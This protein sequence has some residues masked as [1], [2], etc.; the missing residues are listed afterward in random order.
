MG[1]HHPVGVPLLRQCGDRGYPCVSWVKHVE[2]E[3][4]HARCRAAVHDGLEV[5]QVVRIA[6]VADDDLRQVDPLLSEQIQR[7]Q[8]GPVCGIGVHGDGHSC[9]ALGEGHRAGDPLDP[10]RQ[11]LLL[12]DA[13]EK[14][15]L[16]P[17][18]GDAVAD[19]A[20]EQV[21]HQLRA[22]QD[23]PRA[24]VGEVVRE[25][26]EGVEPGR[27]DDVQVGDLLCDALH[28]RDVAAQPDDRRVDDGGDAAAHQVL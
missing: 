20:N 3:P 21:S 23:R 11:P 18:V 1:E 10:R 12:H 16:D 17:G 28:A 9:L 26:V 19:V 7:G 2:A 22:I 8:P 24:T 27:S 6:A 13:F 25:L 14:G 5:V 15:G 4:V